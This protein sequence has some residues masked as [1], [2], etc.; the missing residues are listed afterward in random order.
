MKKI[1]WLR[2]NFS[3]IEVPDHV[4]D[5]AYDQDSDQVFI[6]ASIAG[7]ENMVFLAACTAGVPIIQADKWVYLPSGFVADQTDDKNMARAIR[8]IEKGVRNSIKRG[9]KIGSKGDRNDTENRGA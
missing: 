7:Q 4:R 5:V 2:F 3:G 8:N 6:S 1:E 9:D